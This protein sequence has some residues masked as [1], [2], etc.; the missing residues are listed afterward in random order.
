MKQQESR[1]SQGGQVAPGTLEG[2][3]AFLNT[4]WIPNDT[5]VPTDA[6]ETLEEM[7]RFFYTAFGELNGPIVPEQVRQLRTDLRAILGSS[8]VV[9]LDQWLVRLPVEVRLE[10]NEQGHP[11]IRYQ[12]AQ[13]SGC[14]LCAAILALVVEAIAQQTWTRLKACPDCQWV[15]YDH[16][17][18]RSKVWCLMVAGGSL[19]RSCGSI[20]KVRSFRERRKVSARQAEAERKEFHDQRKEHKETAKEE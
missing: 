18:N 17:K 9:A 5:H 16:T 20:A 13:V 7:Q 14:R 3:R 19:G 1:E 12:P 11:A 4:W 2:V 15:F 6:L 8:E 10:K